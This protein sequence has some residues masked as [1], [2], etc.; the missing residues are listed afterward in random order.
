MMSMGQS[1]PWQEALKTI[2]GATK[3]SAEPLMEFYK[4]LHVWL[5]KQIKENDIP[6]GW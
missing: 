5:E 1:R 3:I 6:V 2:T 4:P